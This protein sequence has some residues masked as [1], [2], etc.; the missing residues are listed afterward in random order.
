MLL[1]KKDEAGIDLNNEENDFLLADVPDSEELEELN[2]TCIMMARL[3]SVNNDTKAG[4]SY[5]SDFAN[6]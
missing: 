4:P 6:E 1:A 3:Q 5:N 2:T